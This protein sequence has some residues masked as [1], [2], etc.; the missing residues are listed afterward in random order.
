MQFQRMQ[1]LSPIA[2]TLHN[3]EEAV[4]MAKWVSVHSGQLPLHPA[5]VKIRFA[6]LLLALAAFAVTYLSAAEPAVARDREDG[7]LIGSEM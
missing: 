7:S 1:W 5:T 6:L 3:S 4:Y 2:V